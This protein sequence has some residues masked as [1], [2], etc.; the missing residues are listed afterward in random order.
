MKTKKVMKPLLLSVAFLTIMTA[1]LFFGMETG[2]DISFKE[3]H[4]ENERSIISQDSY[5][6]CFDFHSNSDLLFRTREEY[7]VF[8]KKLQPCSEKGGLGEIETDFSNKIVIGKFTSGSCGSYFL[9]RFE[10]NEATNTITYVVRVRPRPCIS[11]PAQKSLNLVEIDA[12]NLSQKIN[13]KVE[14]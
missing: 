7:E 14:E 3:L 10:K 13:Y 1:A 5:I 8:R 6:K 11:G 12:S 4:P 9:K 2:T